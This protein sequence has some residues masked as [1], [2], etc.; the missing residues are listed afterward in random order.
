M[1]WTSIIFPATGRRPAGWAAVAALAL[2]AVLWQ[3]ERAAAAEPVDVQLVLA[4]DTSGSVNQRRFELQQ[5]GY[6]T[7][8]RDPRVLQAIQAGIAR[9]I[10]VTMFQWTGPQL[11]DIVVPW[12]RIDD[13]ASA[14][15]VATAIA[16][17]PR[18]LFRGGT[19][20]SGAIDYSMT[21]F[22][23]SPYAGSRRI[24]DVSGDGAN[25]SGRPA[26]H[27]RDDAVAAGVTINGLPILTIE[28]NLDQHY[29]N[30]VIGGEG[31]FMIIV[32]TDTDFADAILKKLIAEIALNKP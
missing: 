2:F 12:M 24:I 3:S 6:V 26:E 28:P 14:E 23:D 4:I 32:E 17:V 7:A 1:R 9:S 22:P 13:Q 27:A 18:Q 25:N 31:A 11:H 8:F 21:L 10:A 20:I 29:Q 16:A 15:A 19:S 30:S 5:Q